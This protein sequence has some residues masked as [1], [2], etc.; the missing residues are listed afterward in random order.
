MADG[1]CKN[2]DEDKKSSN[3]KSTLFNFWVYFGII[4][5]AIIFF[6]MIGFLIY[7]L[8]SKSESPSVSSTRP[9][10]SSSN[11]IH[12]SES[13]LFKNMPEF[14]SPSTE[15]ISAT[16]TTDIKDVISPEK[17]PFLNALMKTTNEK[18]SDF[19]SPLYTRDLTQ[20]AKKI[21]GYRCMNLRRF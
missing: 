9:I 13:K 3:K 5:L 14:A 4:I 21:G 8:F 1:I 6:V 20:T 15:H 7:S 10:Y 17:K 19:V 16:R 2:E 12:S 11:E 18:T